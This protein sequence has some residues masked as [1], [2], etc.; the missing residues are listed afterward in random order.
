VA[1][2]ATRRAALGALAGGGLLGALGL[3]RAPILAQTPTCTLAFVATVRLGPS[4]EPPLAGGAGRPGELRGELS[5]SLAETGRLEAGSLRL[6]DG[7]RLPVVGQATGHA[8][9]VRI[10]LGPRQ[11]VVALGVGEQEVAAC[12]GA[13]DGTATGP[14]VG[15]LGDWHAVAVRRTGTGGARSGGVAGTAT[16]AGTPGAAASGT[17]GA[18]ATGTATPTATATATPTATPTVTPTPTATPTATPAPTPAPAP[19]ATAP[20]ADC[21][22]GQTDCY[23]TCADLQT[24]SVHCGRCR[25]PC[26]AQSTCQS[27]ICVGTVCPA[28]L[29]GCD[30]V[31]VNLQSDNTNCGDCGFHCIS[32]GTACIG[33]ACLCSGGSPPCDGVCPNFSTDPA[34]CGGCGTRC[35]AAQYC[36]VGVCKDLEIVDEVD[37]PVDPGDLALTCE[38]QGL[39]TCGGVCVDISS[40]VYNCGGCGIPCGDLPCI[41]GGCIST[42]EN[43]G[44]TDCGVGYCVDLLSDHNHCGAC[45]NA[46]YPGLCRAGQGTCT[47]CT[48]GEIVPGY[49]ADNPG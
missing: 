39:T 32:A 7:T 9:Q 22:T 6:A 26:P 23:G 17:P 10:A 42:C 3:K 37:P 45:G 19:T 16:A 25:N 31:C 14:Q 15:D 13:V 40:D 29:T 33:G 20:A 2:P 24:S 8:L 28:G 48:G 12:Q 49:C 44:L 34:H 18:T 38:A 43:L 46:C 41:A 11:A 35:L 21:P 4:T 5:F 36:E 27:G 30:G 47:Q 1:A